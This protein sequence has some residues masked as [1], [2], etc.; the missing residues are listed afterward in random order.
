MRIGELA[1]ATGVAP[2]ALRYYEEAGL[3]EAAARTE[4]GYRIYEP[5][6]LGRVQFIQ[7]AQALGLS[8]REIRR[9]V[10]SPRVDG[11]DERRALRHVVAHK[12]AET[13]SRVGEL[14]RLRKELEALYVRLNRVPGPDC[15]HVGDCGC[16]LPTEEEVLKMA[17]EVAATE[18]CTCCGCTEPGC[19]CGCS[20]CGKD[21]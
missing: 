20:C 14:Q 15:G 18:A 2:S 13:K 7:R 8:V 12:L 19:D 6:A 5:A 16:W 1:S 3:L 10:H 9:L 4:S 21:S 17:A 11:A